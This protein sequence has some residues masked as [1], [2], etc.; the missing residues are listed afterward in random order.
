M[1]LASIS[2]LLRAL[3]DAARL[4]ILHLLCSEELSV[5]ELVRIV[6]LPQS[7]VSRHLKAL[8][9]QG[10]VADRPDGAATFYRASLEAELGNGDTRLRDAVAA[11][12]R[13]M[14]LA[15]TDKER[16]T[17]ELALREAEGDDYFDRMGYRW[18]ALREN[19]FGA[20]FHL[21]AM[22]RLLPSQWTVADLGT[23]TG[24]LLPLLGSHFRSV[25]AVDQSRQMLDLAQRRVKETGLANV[26]LRCGHLEQ[27]PLA[28]GEADLALAFLILHHVADVDEALRQIARVL[29]PGGRAVV[30]EIH[31]HDNERFRA[32]MGDRKPGD[33]ARSLARCDDPG[34]I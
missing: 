24:Y 27:L 32:R 33:R 15:P 3:G 10:L 4:R 13:E 2:D 31:A 20:T 16:L 14:P 25:V 18:D 6:G 22:V 19:C 12:L 11:L 17:R 9:D 8:R 26:D 7:S 34:R 28:D 30:V 29:R 23:G 21:E 5:G 1:D